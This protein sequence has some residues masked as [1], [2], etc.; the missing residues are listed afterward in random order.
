MAEYIRIIPASN[1]TPGQAPKPEELQTGEL[2]LNTADGLLYTKTAD[3]KIAICGYPLPK[4]QT[5][6]DP[7]PV[8]SECCGDYGT[9]SGERGPAAIS[10]VYAACISAG[11]LVRWVQDPPSGDCGGDTLNYT[12][13]AKEGTEWQEVAYAEEGG[14]TALLP[15]VAAGTLVRVKAISAGGAA[16]TSEAVAVQDCGSWFCNGSTCEPSSLTAGAG[17]TFSTLALCSASCNSVQPLPLCNSSVS[18]SGGW[19]P[20]TCVVNVGQTVAFTASGTVTFKVAPDAD[21]GNTA[22][23]DGIIGYPLNQSIPGFEYA[24]CSVNAGWRHMAL[25]GRI[26]SAGTPFL[27]GSSKTITATSA[28]V[29]Q[30]RANDTCSSDNS[31]SYT[32]QVEYRNTAP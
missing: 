25:I 19:V 22:N 26:G 1:S 18:V 15:P 9:Y 11:T 2:A 28:G 32:V 3:G 4:N 29:I 27:I 12:V 21:G 7:S 17:T 13:E 5:T 16:T 23:P 24:S 14:G 31:G 10:A 20:T 6:S 30:L 8:A